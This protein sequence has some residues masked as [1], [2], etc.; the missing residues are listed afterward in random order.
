MANDNEI[1][2]RDKQEVD[3]TAGE[4]TWAGTFFTP[5]ADIYS[6]DDAITVVADMPGVS[7]DALE[8]DLRE[9]VLTLTGKVE[10]P[11]EDYRE[12]QREYRIGGYLRKFNISDQI[13]QSAI[14]ATLKDGVL[15]LTLPKAEE[16]RPR[17]IQVQVG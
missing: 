1:E 6:T 13:D 12:L 17:K 11:P 4:P 16:A 3:A 10:T 8:I 7:K 9:G 2:I 15:T 14:E 5:A